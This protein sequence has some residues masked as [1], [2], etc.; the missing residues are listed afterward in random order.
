MAEITLSALSVCIQAVDDLIIKYDDL[1]TSGTEEDLN[2]LQMIILSYEKIALELK[3][4]YKKEWEPTIN[5][6]S[7]EELMEGR[8]DRWSD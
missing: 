1:L 7:Y 4:A 6:P 2:D 5:L 3:K 8:Q